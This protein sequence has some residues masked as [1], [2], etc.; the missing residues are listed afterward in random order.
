[1]D[2]KASETALVPVQADLEVALRG[3][4]ALGLRHG[5]VAKNIFKRG[6]LLNLLRDKAG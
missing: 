6:S 1:M 5:C 3:A 4:L 2:E